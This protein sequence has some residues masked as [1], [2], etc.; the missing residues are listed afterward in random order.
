LFDDT[1]SPSSLIT[2]TPRFRTRL[3]VVTGITDPLAYSPFAEDSVYNV[4]SSSR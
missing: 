2:S 4:L 3:E 1:D